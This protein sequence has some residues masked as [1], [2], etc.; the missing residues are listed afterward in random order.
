[1]NVHVTKEKDTLRKCTRRKIPDLPEVGIALSVFSSRGAQHFSLT[2][3]FFL[4]VCLVAA[5][6]VCTS[7]KHG[8]SRGE[9]RPN[10]G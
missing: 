2:P 5:P 8:A 7:T 10:S 3:R 4:V 6:R 1:M 9:F